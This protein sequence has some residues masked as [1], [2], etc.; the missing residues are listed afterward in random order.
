[1]PET[2]LVTGL[3]HLA[4]GSCMRLIQPR[5]R[6]SV[7]A[8]WPC[9]LLGL[10]LVACS[11]DGTSPSGGLPPPTG[12]LVLSVEG[13][14]AGPAAAVTI[15]GPANYVRSLTTS[16]TLEGLVPG[17]YT[18]T[19]GEVTAGNHRWSPSPAVQPVVVVAGDAAGYAQVRYTIVTGSL[20]VIVEGLPPGAQGALTVSGPAA[21]SEAITATALFVGVVPGLYAV[22]GASLTHGSA[23]YAPSLPAG[24][25]TVKPGVLPDT[26]LV[27]YARQ[28]GQI[29]LAVSGLPAGA[30]AGV[31]ISGP[32]G[33][34]ATAGGSGTLPGLD[35]GSYA[36]TA[37]PVVHL[38]HTWTPAPPTQTA[39]VTIGA[40][41]S[42]GVA[43]T[44]T[45]GALTLTVMGLPTGAPAQVTLTGPGGFYETVTETHAFVGLTPGAYTVS[46]ASVTVNGDVYKATPAQFDMSVSA[47]TTPSL[48][49]VA[50]K[51]TTG[52]LEVVVSGLPTGAA[53]DIRVTGPG[54]STVL[55][56][57]TTLT[58]LVPGAYTV[59][60]T[61]VVHG[62]QSFTPSSTSQTAFVAA[63][64]TNSVA[65]AYSIPAPPPPP[66][67]PG[68]LNL[69]IDGMYLTQAAQRYDGTVPLVA[70]RDAY[71]RVFVVANQAN[72]VT[73]TVRVQLFS[74][75]TLLQTYSLPAP[76]PSVGNAPD[77]ST[78]T[79]SWN[80]RVPG[81][82]IQPNLRVLVELD[83]ANVIAEADETD[84]IFPAGGI[85]RAV[86]VRALP[87][88]QLRFVPVVQQ[89]NG[90]QGDVSD[91]NREQFLEATKSML[92]VAAYD[93]DV[94]APYTTT[95]PVLL[96]NN[97]NG[98]WG[99]I[100]S[101]VLALRSADASTRYYYGVVHTTYTSG[102][103]GIGY[104]GGNLNT[105][106]GWDLF[107]SGPTVMAH[108]LGHN[109]SRL[110][111]PCGPV[112]G[113]DVNYPYADGGIGIWGLDVA[114]LAL[115]PPTFYA[116]LMG[117]C[118]PRW[119]SDY[120]WEWMVAYRGSGPSNV[121]AAGMRVTRGLLVW[122]RIGPD[123]LV[124]EPAFVVDAPPS[125]APPGSARLELL[126]ADGSVLRMQ[127]FAPMEV[128]DLPGGRE[129][130]FALVVPLDRAAELELASVRVTAG[131]RS[132][133]RRAGPDA[134]PV[135]V[136]VD[137]DP[138][139]RI[140][141]AWDV[142]R[143][144]MVLVRDGDTGQIL[145]F[146]RG[147]RV[148][149]PAGVRSLDLTW[150][151]GVRTRREIRPLR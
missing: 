10:I 130:A 101:E 124:L 1:M 26:V 102:V 30:D 57:T 127:D 134:P 147:G 54:T 77:E 63:G 75:A 74:G 121:V 117:Y 129:E 114:T 66:P 36:I 97:V 17:V 11:S 86:D 71:L 28:T 110:H 51:V 16:A 92:P 139:G 67:P 39:A 137:R 83:P 79:T 82:L 68:A 95:A 118:S 87:T 69:Q 5:P 15:T 145:S 148:T 70:G 38:G 76:G 65:V 80:V 138:A 135:G 136:T 151:D 4:P 34:T 25:I 93:A 55:T 90:L 49:Q 60:A 62:G 100:L 131:G 126:A 99:T 33:F 64:V 23:V 149:L 120:N 142:S 14:D 73:P 112:A 56:A 44:V 47:G 108:E 22:A 31:A 111:A 35:P 2:S 40:T 7:F 122:G 53:A 123:G 37:S 133:M 32:G 8:A 113:V 72:L 48:A 132:A 6:F 150:S 96:A 19:A 119:V 9:V 103:A 13:V 140:V 27:T 106:L 58:S 46:A 50:Y 146:A 3:W 98:A 88:F 52:R 128:A 89:V 24:P 45:T 105:A 143:H 85:P 116:D 29:A 43:Y 91:A 107:P 18:V 115:K 78:L 12:K 84:N 42:A 104:V 144:P 59:A 94:R 125:A 81:V 109:M 21:F 41:T 20:F 141:L 61:A